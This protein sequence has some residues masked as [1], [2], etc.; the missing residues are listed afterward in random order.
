MTTTAAV[1]TQLTTNYDCSS[2]ALLLKN[3]VDSSRSAYDGALE[4]W[5]AGSSGA[6]GINE[7]W[8]ARQQC[9][10]AMPYD[11]S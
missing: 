7:L 11:K 6:P 3:S 8:N 5:T 4:K 1:V 2:A 10:C 9:G